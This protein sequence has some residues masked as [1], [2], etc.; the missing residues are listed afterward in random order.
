MLYPFRHPRIKEF[1]RRYKKIW[2]LGHAKALLEWDMEVN[3]PE[4][5]FEERGIALSEIEGMITDFYRSEEIKRLFEGI[6]EED[7]NEY[8]RGLVRVVRRSIEYYNKIPKEL[9]MEEQ[10]LSAKSF[11]VWIRAK[12]KSDFKLFEPYLKE[13]VEIERKKAE[14]LGYEDHPYNALLDLYEE[15]YTIRDFDKIFSVIKSELPPFYKKMKYTE[16]LPL[17]KERFRWENAIEMTKFIVKKLGYPSGRGHLGFVEHPMTI[18]ISY[19]DVRITI[20][21]R[22]IDFRRILFA[23]IHEFG[24]ALY[25]LNIDENLKGTPLEIGVSYGIHESQSRFWENIIGRNYSFIERFHYVMEAFLPF[26]EK[27]S[28]EEI[29]EYFTLVRPN[30]IRIEADEVQYNFHILLRYEIEKDLIEGKI[31]VRELPEIWSE[32]MERYI[33]ITPK[34]DSEGVLQDVHWAQ[35]AFGYFPTY[36]LGN[37]IAAQIYERFQEESGLLDEFI[38]E[39]NFAKIREFLREKIHKYGS[40][41]PPKELLKRSIGEEANPEVFVDYIKKKYKNRILES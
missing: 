17:E 39:G 30:P 22:E 23:G 2:A 18:K 7:L 19:N 21:R 31:N 28:K 38:L 8:E 16:E 26:L 4:R 13:M 14:Y 20:Q 27:Y 15:G 11:K 3:L 33:G 9:L 40:V 37:I 41:F 5:A 1:L 25:E 34:N 35:G 36:A 32:K 24:H 29:Y 6:K 12:E 10:E